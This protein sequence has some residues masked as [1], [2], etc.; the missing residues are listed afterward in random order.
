MMAQ[1]SDRRPTESGHDDPDLVGWSRQG[2]AQLQAVTTGAGN[3]NWSPATAQV[4]MAPLRDAPPPADSP[5]QRLSQMRELA[6]YAP[7]IAHQLR[8]TADQLEAEASDIEARQRPAH[9]DP[10]GRE[11]RPQDR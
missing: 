2:I 1:D 9:K 4:T 3:R 10:H 5:R 11:A 7:E 8:H 6:D